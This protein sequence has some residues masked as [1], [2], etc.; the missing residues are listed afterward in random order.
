MTSNLPLGT[1]VIPVYNQGSYLA[2]AIKSVLDQ[3]YPAIEMVVVDDG[4]TDETASVIQ[5]FAARVLSIPQSNHGAAHALNT[6]IRFGSGE[7]VCWLSADDKFMP[8]KVTQQ[9]EAFAA[10]LGL[11]VSCTA[12]RLVDNRDQLI[13]RIAVPEWRHPDAFISIFWA[14]PIN[15]SSVMI[16]REVFEDMGGFDES[17][18]ADV[19]GAMWLRCARH[20]AFGQ[21]DEPLTEYRVHANTLS[22]NRNLMI[23]SMARV[24]MPYV[25]DG[26]V[27]VRAVEHDP[28]PSYL[29][30]IMARDF[31]WWG[32]RELSHGL[33]ESSRMVGTS[34]IAQAQTAAA[35]RLTASPVVSEAVR[36][37]GGAARRAAWRR[38]ARRDPSR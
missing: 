3:D 24:R 35:L 16:R 9:V 19:D 11:G 4:S 2:A 33:L 26:S 15:G 28:D 12:A 30:A 7:L 8:T 17:L 22:A 36:R 10:D 31:A 38:T 1:V 5:S 21:L 20:Y 18:R 25:K 6:G 34:R 14:N 32:M 23:E 13:R 37:L 27:R 29:L